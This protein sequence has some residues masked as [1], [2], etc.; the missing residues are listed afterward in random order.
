MTLFADS[1]LLPLWLSAAAA[2]GVRVLVQDETV[3]LYSGR[4]ERQHWHVPSITSPAAPAGSNGN[5]AA[6]AEDGGGSS[7]GG[8]ADAASAAADDDAGGSF[9]LPGGA[10]VTLRMVASARGGSDNGAAGEGSSSAASHRGLLIGLH[11]LD[12]TGSCMF[13]EREYDGAGRLLEVRQ[14]TAVKGGWSGGRM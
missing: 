14:G 3:V 7:A 10:V 9:W 12:A 11:M 6:A 1:L 13:V 2:I 5:A 8:D 4:E